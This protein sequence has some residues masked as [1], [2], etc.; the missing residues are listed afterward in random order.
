VLGLAA[1]VLVTGCNPFRS[2][3]SSSSPKRKDIPI[4]VA[5]VIPFRSTGNDV[6]DAAEY[7]ATRILA[8]DKNTDV[9][10]TYA[11]LALE[12]SV[13]H[14]WKDPQVKELIQRVEA[15][16]NPDGGFGLGQESDA[17]GDGTFNPKDNTYTITST[18]HVG[19]LYLAAFRAKAIPREWLVKLVDTVVKLPRIKNG[20]C[21]AYSMSKYDAAGPC[22][23]NVVAGVAWF[24]TEA[25]KLGIDE[26]GQAALTAAM[27]A[28]NNRMYSAKTGQW[29]YQ[30]T[31]PDALQDEPHNGVNI[32]A[33]VATD[34]ALGKLAAQKRAAVWSAKT[35]AQFAWARVAAY[36]C[37]SLARLGPLLVKEV[38]APKM[39]TRTMAQAAVFDARADAVCNLHQAL[40]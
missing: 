39:N 35:S 14:G 33:L 5:K 29:P 12:R 17:F 30:S 18:D 36:D 6:R 23:Y 24:L 15:R 28:T 16:R 19:R 7:A 1:V 31:K 13:Y 25:K 22:V 20:T 10:Q 9:A 26:P 8:S 2:P 4:P 40:F 38:Q 34:P 11:F 27:V 32:D 37:P 3:S 21:V